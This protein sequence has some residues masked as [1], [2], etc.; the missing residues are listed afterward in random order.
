MRSY[1]VNFG[2]SHMSAFNQSLRL[3]RTQR[4]GTFCFAPWQMTSMA[5]G[6]ADN[7]RLDD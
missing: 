5:D 3:L 1:F 7:R 4:F 6:I 2:F